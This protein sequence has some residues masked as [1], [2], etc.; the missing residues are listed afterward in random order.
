VG[1]VVPI[2]SGRLAKYDTQDCLL[3][4]MRFV[5]RGRTHKCRN[6]TVYNERHRKIRFVCAV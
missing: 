6:E 1:S 3:I 5:F 4:K 2:E